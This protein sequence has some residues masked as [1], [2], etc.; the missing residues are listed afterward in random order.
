MTLRDAETSVNVDAL[1]ERQRQ[2]LTIYDRLHEANAHKWKPIPVC[3]IPQ[4][5]RG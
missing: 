5:M 1:T 3:V 4:E 2:V